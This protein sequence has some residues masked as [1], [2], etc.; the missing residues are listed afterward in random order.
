MT[1]KTIES[2]ILILGAGING[3]STAYFL[4]KKGKKVAVVDRIDKL[5][6]HL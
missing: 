2:D 3:N 6:S 5:G 4:S 1:E